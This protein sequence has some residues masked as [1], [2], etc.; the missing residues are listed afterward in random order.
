MKVSTDGRCP[1]CG[2][3]YRI[4]RGRIAMLQGHRCRDCGAEYATW[5]RT[6]E[7]EYESDTVRSA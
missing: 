7:E 5:P 4:E 2:S 3:R 6:Q 1:E